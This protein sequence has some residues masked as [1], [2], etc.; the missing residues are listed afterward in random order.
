MNIEEQKAIADELL[1]CLEKVC[2]YAILAG[3]A[4]RD[5]YMGNTCN[6]LDFYFNLDQ[7]NTARFDSKILEGVLP[8]GMKVI[9][10]EHSPKQNPLYKQMKTLRR[11]YYMEYKG[12]EFQLMRMH[13]QK[14]VWGVVGTFDCSIC[15][16][17][18]KRGTIRRTLDFKKTIT[19]K[20][21]FLNEGYSWSD[22]HPKK[23]VERF[24]GEYY[25]GTL[26]S[27]DR[28]LMQLVLED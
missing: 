27:C 14:D 4:P 16:I 18:Y 28:K 21:M 17:W 6:D 22:Y 25:T 3:G 20:I 5:W 9:K 7:D 13:T 10:L 15:K 23:M 2:P 12:I 26:E 24:K 19:S 1:Q 11:I 8:E